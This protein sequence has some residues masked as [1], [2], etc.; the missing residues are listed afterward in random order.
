MN[1][2]HFGEPL[3]LPIEGSVRLPRMTT[4]RLMALVAIA[5]LAAAAY[6]LLFPLRPGDD[7]VFF[8]MT[9]LGLMCGVVALPFVA[10]W[11]LVGRG[12][13]PPPE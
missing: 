4:R 6:R 9:G 5:G 1:H 10:Y 13:R 3:T 11:L 12:D 2:P 7:I 8:A